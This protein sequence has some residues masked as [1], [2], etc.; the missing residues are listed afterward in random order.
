MTNIASLLKS[1][2]SRISRKEVRAETQALKKAS[3]QYRSDIAALKRR[4]AEQERQ[5]A[6]LRKGKPA[7]AAAD[8]AQE[9]PQLRF[10]AGGFASLRKK[11]GLS[12][13]DMGKLLGVSLQT[14]YHW[15]KGLSKPRASQLQGIA[16]VRK[17]GKRGAA[18]RLAE[19]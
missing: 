11:L 18:A 5:I 2:I 7:A 14:I 15:E 6:R 3:T 1:E 10:R 16:E 4:V 17:L 13:A 8:P 9:A 19:A 12:A